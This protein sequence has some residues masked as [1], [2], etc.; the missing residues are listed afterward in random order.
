MS[1]RHAEDPLPHDGRLVEYLLFRS[2]AVTTKPPS[3]A[4][5]RGGIQ[6]GLIV[7]SDVRGIG[8]R[9]LN[10]NGLRLSRR[11]L[12]FSMSFRLNIGDT[13]NGP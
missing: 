1:V 8:P 9:S 3:L 5:R 10:P 13:F 4:F 6:T 12:S 7:L 11:L 2:Y